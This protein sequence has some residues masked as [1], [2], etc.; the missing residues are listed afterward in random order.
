MMVL[1]IMLYFGP[2]QVNARYRVRIVQQTFDGA[3]SVSPADQIFFGK[4]SVFLQIDNPEFLDYDKEQ[5]R[6]QV[7]I[8]RKHLS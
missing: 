8:V 4:G 6:N 1:I 5:Y 7:V 2:Q 3:F